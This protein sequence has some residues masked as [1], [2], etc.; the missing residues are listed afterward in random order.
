MPSR[1]EPCGLNQMYSLLY[2][3]APLVRATG[4]LAEMVSRFEPETGEGTGFVF[5]DFTADARL[6][7]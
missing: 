2:G 5:D 3:T 7:G 4:G 6:L 1:C